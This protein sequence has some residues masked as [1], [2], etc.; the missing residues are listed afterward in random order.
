MHENSFRIWCFSVVSFKKLLKILLD[1]EH[2]DM[3]FFGYTVKR[4]KATLRDS[5]KK[6]RR[7][8][9]IV[10]VLESYLM[11]VPEHVREVFYDTG[12]VKKGIAISL[13]GDD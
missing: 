2:L 7:S 3:V 4:K 8:Q 12:I 11:P 13:G 10:A 1:F 6:N 9:K 5:N